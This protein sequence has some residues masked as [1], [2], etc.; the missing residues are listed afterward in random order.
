MD[1]N[2][3]FIAT[4]IGI[5]TAFAG[6][7][8]GYV[9]AHKQITEL[10]ERNTELRTTLDMERSTHAEKIKHIAEAREQLGESF[11]SLASKALSHNS[12]EF[13]KLAQENLKQY[14]ANAHNELEKKE[15]SISD[16]V[17]PI[18]DAL[19]K[20][21]KQIR[22]MEQERKQAYG[23]LKQHLESMSH[24]QSQLQLETRNLV[25][26]LRRPEVRGQW[27]EMTLKRLAELSGMVEHCDFYEQQHVD[28]DEGRMRPDMIIRLPDRREIVVDVKTPLDSYLNAIEA[29]DDAVREEHLKQH[30]R[31]VRD[32]IREL[33]AKAYWNQFKDAPDF[34]VLFIP[35]DQ[36]LSAALERDPNILEDAMSKQ[37]ILA[38]PSSFVALLRAVA[39]GWR[40]EALAENADR[41]RE[42]GETLYER[43]AGFSTHLNKLGNSLGSSVENF[44]K[45]VGSFDSRILPSARRFKEMGI[46][47]KKVIKDTKQIDKVTRQISEQD[48]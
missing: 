13:L 15:K 18:R 45:A 28:T 4:T 46:N 27:G 17:A 37:I 7:L 41:I 48:E 29:N 36:F 16:L 21:E 30:T 32:R 42:L 8:L 43:L 5:I 3:I 12:N 10:R 33:S 47:D 38:T 14:Q 25:T 40:Q 24:T 23:S 31:K 39:F 22:D 1:S 6:F 35:G 19:N 44:N 2:L 34:V 20:T 26:A 11:A 9:R